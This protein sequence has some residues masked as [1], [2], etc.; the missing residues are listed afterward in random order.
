M[1]ALVVDE[2]V[3]VVHVDGGDGDAGAGGW[4]R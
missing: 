3:M 2:L 4:W 1:V